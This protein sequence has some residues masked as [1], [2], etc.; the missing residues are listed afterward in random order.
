MGLF[1]IQKFKGYAVKYYY[2]IFKMIYNY[3]LQY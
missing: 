2:G 3:S 1:Y